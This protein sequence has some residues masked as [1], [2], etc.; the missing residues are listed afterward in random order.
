MEEGRLLALSSIGLTADKLDTVRQAPHIDALQ[1]RWN[2]SDREP[3]SVD[4]VPVA[5]S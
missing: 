1:W 4:T 3:M 5:T 2:S